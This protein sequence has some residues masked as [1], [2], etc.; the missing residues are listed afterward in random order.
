LQKQTQFEVCYPSIN[1][2]LADKINIPKERQIICITRAATNDSAHK[3]FAEIE[4]ALSE[5]MRGY[6]LA[7]LVGRGGFGSEMTR[8]LE[9]KTR[10]LGIQVKWLECL[11]D[12]EKFREIKKSKLMLF[13]SSFEGYGYPPVEA[14]YCGV[15]CVVYD[16]PVLREVSGAC[17]YYVPQG[18]HEALRTMAAKALDQ[19]LPVSPEVWRAT[20]Q[21]ITFEACAQRLYE[22]ISRPAEKDFTPS[23]VNAGIFSRFFWH[24]Q[25][26]FFRVRSYLK[27]PLA[28]RIQHSYPFQWITHQLRIRNLYW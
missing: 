3:G 18:D 16:L 9:E 27:V 19:P 20:R 22:I 24:L 14:V 4:H 10:Q 8:R 13:L 28:Q 12:K 11:N 26:Q 5:A 2:S 17:L 23:I 21:K 25:L 7:V 15:P 1:S 6:T